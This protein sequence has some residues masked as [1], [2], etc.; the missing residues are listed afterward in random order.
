VPERVGTSHVANL[1]PA[2]RPADVTMGLVAE[3]IHEDEPDTT[4]ATVRT[5]LARQCP[6]W[7]GL[8]LSYLQ[9][10]GSDNAMWR[11]HGRDDHDLVV[12]LPRR[13][14]AAANIGQELDLL[15][16]LTETAGL[17]S[18]VHTPAVRHVGH[19]DDAFPHRW[20]VLD[21]LDGV[22][23]WTARGSLD[24]DLGLLAV[25]IARTVRAIGRLPDMPVAGREPGDRGGP[26]APLLR[27]LEWWITD[28]RWNASSLVDVAAVRRVAAEA[29]EL[30]DDPVVETFVHGDLIPGNVLVHRGVLSAVIDWG[31]AA[32]ADPAQDL[33]PAWALFDERGRDAF[34][35]A[36]EADDASW[37]R[38]KVFELEH[39]VGGVLYYTPRRHPLG[40]LMTRTLNRIL[41]DS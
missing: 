21:W 29:Q 36:I 28:P 15:Q 32:I 16:H 6:E 22:D 11:L 8:P 41:A 30:A 31:G 7:T 1:L 39:A 40:D 12:R 3:W 10:S 23:A 14:R 25:D 37:L 19:P 18:V 9:T 34:R 38:A 2:A 27:R 5:L 33:A 20:G 35:E 26:L 24:G 4:E 13:V 17:A